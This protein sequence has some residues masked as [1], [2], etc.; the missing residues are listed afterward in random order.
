MTATCG[1]SGHRGTQPYS[2]FA[3]GIFC[4]LL[5][6]LLVAAE[7]RVGTCHYTTCNDGGVTPWN[8]PWRKGGGTGQILSCPQRDCVERRSFP[9]ATPQDPAPSFSRS[10]GGLLPN[11]PFSPASYPFSLSASSPALPSPGVRILPHVLS[12]R[13]SGPQRSSWRSDQPWGAPARTMRP[14][15]SLFSRDLGRF[16]AGPGARDE[17]H[18]R[19]PVPQS[20]G[21]LCKGPG[22]GHLSSKPQCSGKPGSSCPFRVTGQPAWAQ[23]LARC[24]NGLWPKC[25]A[26]ANHWGQLQGGNC[27]YVGWKSTDFEEGSSSA[28]K[29]NEKR[30]FL[31]QVSTGCW[32]T[33]R[34]KQQIKGYKSSNWKNIYIIYKGT[35]IC[36]VW[37]PLE[38]RKQ[39]SDVF[40][41]YNRQ[42]PSQGESKTKQ[43]I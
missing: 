29:M 15:G 27:A 31:R 8:D 1:P 6:G 35:G 39:R 26:G 14:R 30:P 13:R 4:L 25:C 3:C 12:P 23:G 37:V 38:S 42:I 7:E 17:K 41:D 36:L 16:E 5:W 21:L 32:A 10:C 40:K 19:A 2:T 34:Q 11:A 20:P 9:D 18:P 28:Q 33:N 43:K 22:S 24:G